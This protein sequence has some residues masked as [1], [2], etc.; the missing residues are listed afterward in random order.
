MRAVSYYSAAKNVKFVHRKVRSTEFNFVR[1]TS[2]VFVSTGETQWIWLTVTSE[3]TWKFGSSLTGDESMT[4]AHELLK[5]LS[6]ARLNCSVSTTKHN[7]HSD[8]LATNTAMLIGMPHAIF[9]GHFCTVFN[10]FIYIFHFL[11]IACFNIERLT[12]S[13]LMSDMCCEDETAKYYA[14]QNKKNWILY[15]D[16]IGTFVSMRNYTAHST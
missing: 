6:W 5:T 8:Q 11:V 7:Q 4:S 1:K 2:A 10:L 9:Y 14:E 13:T 15:S 16:Y 3:M 12:S